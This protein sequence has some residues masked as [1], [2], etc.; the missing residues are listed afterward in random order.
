[1]LRTRNFNHFLQESKEEENLSGV[2]CI[3]VMFEHEEQLAIVKL[4]SGSLVRRPHTQYI[5]KYED[6]K[7][8]V[9]VF[10]VERYEQAPLFFPPNS[11]EGY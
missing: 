5:I 3:A 4:H 7:E 8:K 10:L 2:S 9:E 1:M 6:D 11:Q